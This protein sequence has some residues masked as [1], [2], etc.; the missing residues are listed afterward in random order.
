MS[1]RNPDQ[2]KEVLQVSRSKE[3]CSSQQTIEIDI[4]VFLYWKWVQ[5]VLGETIPTGD[6]GDVLKDGVVLCKLINKLQPGSV[7]KF[8]EKVF[9][10]SYYLISIQISI[11]PFK[12]RV[13][14]SCW[15]K[16][17]KPSLELLKITECR[18]KKCSS[19]PISLKAETYPRLDLMFVPR[20]ILSASLF[21][22]FCKLCR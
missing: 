8:K 7:K 21:L 1:K 5:S 12:T 10:F 22:S 2:E 14:P 16:T 20:I 18:M 11:F 17:S 15:W 3:I 9:L 6:F 4:F 19:L 13:L